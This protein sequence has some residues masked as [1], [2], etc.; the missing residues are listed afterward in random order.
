MPTPATHPQTEHSFGMT[1]QRAQEQAALGVSHADG[2]VVGADEQHAARALLGR[3]QAAHASRAVA[4]EHIQQLHSLRRARQNLTGWTDKKGKGDISVSLLLSQSWPPNRWQVPHKERSRHCAS[5][6]P[7]L[8]ERSPAGTSGSG[9]E[10][11]LTR[12]V[13][14]IGS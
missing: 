3:A 1:V 14:A 2:A 5:I 6:K 10:E 7:C 8:I 11:I 9:F 4:L 13:S 12:N